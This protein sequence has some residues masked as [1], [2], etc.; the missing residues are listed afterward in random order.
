MSDALDHKKMDEA[1]NCIYTDDESGDSGWCALSTDL[2]P[3]H[4]GSPGGL[5]WVRLDSGPLNEFVVVLC[6]C[7]LCT[8]QPVMFS[9]WLLR[10]LSRCFVLVAEALLWLCSVLSRLVTCPFI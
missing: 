7:R 10:G 5:T 8:M 9:S 4:L 1:D 3:A 6:L 2:V